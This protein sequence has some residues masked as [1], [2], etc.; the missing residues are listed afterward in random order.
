MGLYFF[1]R[2]LKDSLLIWVL[3]KPVGPSIEWLN[4]KA[5]IRKEN[6]LE[7]SFHDQILTQPKGL[8]FN[9]NDHIPL[10]L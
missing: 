7:T 8:N 10:R 6:I 9:S 4:F 3:L 2:L 1:L 5:I